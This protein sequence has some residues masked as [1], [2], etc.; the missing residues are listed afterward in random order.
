M[1]VGDHIHWY[2]SSRCNL[3][4]TYCFKPDAYFGESRERLETLAQ[5]LVEN[6]VKRVT[7]SG[8]EPTLVKDLENVLKILKEGRIYVSLHTNG[9]LL[10][11]KKI[12]ELSG[13]VDDI[14]L[15]IDSF[16][17]STQKKLERVEFIPTLNRFFGIV[18]AIQENNIGLGYHTVFTGINHQEI[19]EIY[20][21]IKQTDFGYWRI[22]EFNKD[23]ARRR[24]VKKGSSIKDESVQK[25][26]RDR[27]ERID[28]I[29]GYGTF[30]KGNTD[31][32]LAHFI[33]MEQ[34]MKQHKDGRIQFVAIRDA[35]SP[36]AFLDNSGDV[37]FYTWFSDIERRVLGNIIW[38]G[39]PFVKER[40]QEVH[41]KGWEFDA[42]TQNEFINATA[43]DM[44]IWTRLW[45]GSY[46][47]EE[48]ELIDKR[49]YDEISNLAGI[50]EKRKEEFEKNLV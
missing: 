6:D 19:P 10:D 29:T 44:P 24:I 49:F 17:K 5:I 11:D 12:S 41:E 42:T 23:L 2:I 22:Y 25:K 37:R 46:C 18:K 32:L 20:K 45:D 16:H 36:Y 8:G 30:E 43:G 28:S 4:C 1:K 13:L 9:T 47:D 50:Y 14:A 38:D 40:L 21:S 34:Q 33:L 27:L 31:C 3:D 35:E 48:V 39:F 26:L 15:P 7:I